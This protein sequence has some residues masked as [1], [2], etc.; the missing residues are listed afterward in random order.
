MVTMPAAAAWFRHRSVPQQI[1]PQ[2]DTIRGLAAIAVLVGHAN[3]LIV[4]PTDPSLF[5]VTGLAAQAAVMAFFVLSGFLICKSIT[6]NAAGPAGFSAGSYA[7]DRFNRIVP[8]LAFSLLLVL[9][10]WALAPLVFPTGST[11]FAAQYPFFQR[12]EFGVD[13]AS[14]LGAAVFLNGFVTSTPSVNGPL[15][16]LSYEVWYYVAAGLIASSRGGRGIALAVLVLLVLGAVNRPFLIYSLVWFAGAW[17]ALAHNAGRQPGPPERTIGAV[18]LV[19]ALVLA[20]LYVRSSI[21]ISAPAELR[22]QL[23]PY[24]N[25]CV[26]FFFAVVLQ[27]IVNGTVRFRPVVAGSADYSY[28]LY[29]IHYPLILFLYGAMQPRIHGNLAATWLAA[30]LAVATCLLLA[31]TAARWVEH[32]RPIRVVKASAVPAAQKAAT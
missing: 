20:A 32:V 2:L 12:K 15:W 1:S 31:R 25:L 3:Q 29:I 28:T 11:Q 22:L 24:F 9:G 27:E 17:V 10:M 23:V 26:G 8:P 30:L 7:A 19:G 6:R 16:S 18:G 21:G 14:L 4:A 5:A 13:P